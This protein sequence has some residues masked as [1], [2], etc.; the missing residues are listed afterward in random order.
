MKQPWFWK[1]YLPPHAENRLKR[2]G[3]VVSAREDFYKNKPTN[4]TF[5]LEKRYSWM[6]KHINPGDKVLE[7]GCGAG[8][9]RDFIRKD[10]Q[11]ILSD[12]EKH[13]WVDQVVDALNTKIKSN[14]VDVVFCSNTIHHVAYPINFFREMERILKPGGRLLIQEMNCSLMTRLML[15]ILKHEGWSFHRDPYNI[16]QPCNDKDDPWSGNNAVPN[17]LFDDRVSFEKNIPAFS[18]KYHKFSEFC[19]FPLSG[20]V[21]AKAKTIN[22]PWNILKVIDTIDSFLI[23]AAPMVFALQRR[24]VLEKQE[25]LI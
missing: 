1:E 11:L 19:I 12:I 7:V 20:G 13:P 6:N 17:L 18:I 15:K 2:E 21:T 14:S 16:N 25:K 5:L 4:L 3:D 24:I 10:A 22:L 8:F 9:S 23:F